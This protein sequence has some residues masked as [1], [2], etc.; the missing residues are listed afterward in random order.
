MEKSMGKNINYNHQIITYLG[1][2]RK[3]LKEIEDIV[4]EI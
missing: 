3:L 1:N 4:L 2:K